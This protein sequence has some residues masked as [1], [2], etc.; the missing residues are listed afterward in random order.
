MAKTHYGSIEQANESDN[1]IYYGVTLCGL[2]YTES[3]ISNL[4]EE[5]S[6]IKCISIFYKYKNYESEAES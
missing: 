6:C 5:V 1:Q 2:E 4:I 3:P